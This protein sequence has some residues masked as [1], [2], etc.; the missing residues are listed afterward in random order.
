MMDQLVVIGFPFM[1]LRSSDP[2][3]AKVLKSEI[4][5]VIGFPFMYLRSSD[6]TFCWISI[7]IDPL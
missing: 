5:V 7:S 1:Y 4:M 3:Q 2:T 6:P